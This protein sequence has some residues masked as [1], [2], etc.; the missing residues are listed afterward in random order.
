[1][2]SVVVGRHKVSKRAR[3]CRRNGRVNFAEIVAVTGKSAPE[4]I[5]LLVAPV[6]GDGPLLERGERSVDATQRCEAAQ[7]GLELGEREPL[8]GD[9]PANT[10]QVRVDRGVVLGG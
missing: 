3:C 7:G 5:Q 10:R 1:M 6:S 8:S 9:R 2:E 4:R